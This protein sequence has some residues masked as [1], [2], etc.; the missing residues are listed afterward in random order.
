[1]SLVILED[2]IKK[3]VTLT[4]IEATKISKVIGKHKAFLNIVEDVTWWREV[5]NFIFEW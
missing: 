1:M 2:I 3:K 4:D 5:T